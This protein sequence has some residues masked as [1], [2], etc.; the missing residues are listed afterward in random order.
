MA[1]YEDQFG[2]AVLDV[3]LNEGT[4]EVVVFITNTDSGH[5]SVARLTHGQGHDLR[6]DLHTAIRN[7]D[8]SREGVGP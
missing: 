6:D 5:I 2:E 3:R 8:R 4:G 1:E 7:Y